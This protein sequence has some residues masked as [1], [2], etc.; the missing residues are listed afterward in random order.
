M[1]PPSVREL[2]HGTARASGSASWIATVAKP[3]GLVPVVLA[4]QHGAMRPTALIL[5]A[6]LSAGAALAAP[7]V[8]PPASSPPTKEV[9]PVTV[10]P[11]TAAPK[12]VKSYPA[13][14][15]AL[16]AGVTVLA[17]TF[18]QPML[19]S[20]FDVAAASGGEAPPCLKTPRLLDDSKTFVLL[21]T[22]DPRKSYAI[23]F[24]ARPQGGFANVAEHRAE[25][26]ILKF[27]TTDADGPRDVH[28][29]M[30]AANLRDLDM[31]IQESP[32]RRAEATPR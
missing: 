6:A 20:G 30:K 8:A 10:Y 4:P 27:S 19:K 31:P 26:A 7:P 13:E 12:I 15:Q 2:Y 14:G 29:A 17:I 22:T 9:S 16:P 28:A 1:A 21:C 23:A 5:T 32:D 3:W 25:P 11:A 24:N 18:D